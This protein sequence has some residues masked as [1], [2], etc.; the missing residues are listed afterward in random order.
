MLPGGAKS[1]LK[2]RLTSIIND[3]NLSFFAVLTDKCKE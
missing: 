1:M 2:I 3:C